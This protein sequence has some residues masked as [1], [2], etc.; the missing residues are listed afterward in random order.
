MAYVQPS[1]V[2]L[3]CNNPNEITIKWSLNGNSTGYTLTN[4]IL[5]E[6][7]GGTV[8]TQYEI[9]FVGNVTD[10]SGTFLKNGIGGGAVKSY[11]IKA[12]YIYNAGN[13]SMTSLISSV[14]SV[15]V[16]GYPGKPVIQSIN[17]SYPRRMD[18]YWSCDA[19]GSTIQYI[20]VSYTNFTYP[21]LVNR[22]SYSNPI[23]INDIS[24]GNYNVQIKAINIQ[25]LDS[26]YS[27][28]SNINI[29][30][31]PS[32]PVIT[33]ISDISLN[34]VNIQ[35]SYTDNG[36]SPIIG[37][38]YQY[39]Y[40]G[41]QYSKFAIILPNDTSFN[42]DFSIPAASSPDWIYGRYYDSIKIN[43]I[44]NVGVSVFSDASS[45]TPS[46]IPDSI[47]VNTSTIEPLDG[48]HTTLDCS[49]RIFF[50]CK[51]EGSVITEVSGYFFTSNNYS[52]RLIDKLFIVNDL[53]YI[54]YNGS[55]DEYKFTL[56]NIKLNAT[57][58]IQFDCK[59]AKGFSGVPV[60]TSI[61]F[62]TPQLDKVSINT[63]DTATNTIIFDTSSSNIHF[64]DSIKYSYRFRG[65]SRREDGS[66]VIPYSSLGSHDNNKTFGIQDSSFNGNIID[67]SFWLTNAALTSLSPATITVY[68]DLPRTPFI[69]IFPSGE[70]IELTYYTN[71]STPLTQIKYELNREEYMFEYNG[72]T[73][74]NPI[75]IPLPLISNRSATQSYVVRATFTNEF[76][77]SDWSNYAY[78]NNDSVIEYT[79][80][81]QNCRYLSVIPNNRFELSSPYDSGYTK[82]QLDRR[83][84]YEVLQYF[85]NT[86]TSNTKNNLTTKQQYALVSRGSYIRNKNN[87]AGI[88]SNNFECII[89]PN[90]FFEIPLY[91]YTINRQYNK[92]EEYPSPKQWYMNYVKNQV[93][94]LSVS[95][96][97]LSIYINKYVA[98]PTNHISI[99]SSLF[100]DITGEVNPIYYG[101]TT[102]YTIKSCTINVQ[103]TITGSLVRT[104]SNIPIDMSFS[105]TPIEG[106]PS[107]FHVRKYCGD[108]MYT[109]LGLPTTNGLVY[110]VN[111]KFT[112]ESTD[113]INQNN[114]HIINPLITVIS[115]GRL[116]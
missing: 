34:T 35:F 80:I 16:Y 25:N 39:S 98:S 105:F 15:L 31:I 5:Y 21:T 42:A 41:N 13:A 112:V 17:T 29:Y 66:G 50:T 6:V 97:M 1:I 108:F 49:A 61:F 114:R 60:N 106:T 82:S 93:F 22:Y 2:D 36:D 44:N 100:I 107:S 116:L 115:A 104:I 96:T 43:L 53:S 46:T 81:N 19:C 86:S 85:G 4:F 56:A 63:I 99:A 74:T 92:F 64:Y 71:T 77:E 67:C 79:A 83:R 54:G 89:E 26:S 69:S 58:Y 55:K 38:N 73:I 103:N 32:Q 101:I 75:L 90:E 48:S 30:N 87:A 20:D 84:K 18:I 102:T 14:K 52:N 8:T 37:S 9:P 68:M 27:N 40:S 78:I 47:S 59:N 12:S 95:N 7:S 72:D 94:L 76:G 91:N 109:I 11:Q 62:P 28:A 45:Y 3:L 24:K 33:N 88:S 51:N 70:Y 65:S 10:T 57:N 23:I 110:N 111:C 113:D